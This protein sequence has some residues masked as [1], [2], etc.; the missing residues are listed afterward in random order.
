MAMDI[1]TMHIKG[2]FSGAVMALG[3]LA[4]SASL[5]FTDARTAPKWFTDGVMYQ[6]QPRAFTPEGTLKA[7]EGKLP[8]LKETGITIVYL[9][10]V[11]KMDGRMDR[12]F[13]SP[14]QVKSG[15]NIPK[16]QYCIADYFHVDEEYGTDDDLRA[17]CRRAHELGMRVVFDLVYFHCA[18]HARILEQIPDA[19]ARNPDGSAKRGP[20][21]FPKL[22]FKSKAVREYL[23]TNITYL[24]LEYGVDGFRCDVGPGI[25]LDFWIEAHDRMDALSS[26]NAILLC[27]GHVKNDQQRAFDADYGWFPHPGKDASA[28]RRAWTG[29]ERE[30]DRG[31]R[32]VNHYENHDI[33]TDVRPRREAAWGHDFVDQVLVWMFT[34]DGVPLLFNGNEIADDDPKHSMFGH[35]PI[36]W[37][38]LDGD[39]GKARRALVRRLAELR[40]AHPVFTALN[41]YEGLAWLDVTSPREVTAFVRRM[42]GGEMILVVQNWSAKEVE[43]TV[44][45]DTAEPDLPYFVVN[46]DPVDRSVK[47]NPSDNPLMSRRS[48]KTG[49]ATYRLGPHGFCIA[50]V[51]PGQ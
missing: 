23:L 2:I 6:I 22:N 50:V 11:F 47:G 3:A 10:P 13:W 29:R 49:P 38:L 27:E 8:Y 34:I 1:K 28:I 15:F 48:T 46:D 12:S 16:N 14:R 5:H 41:G 40:A 18:P 36:D 39:A 51:E 25:P 35:T 45:L 21:R 30:S 7:A 43:A 42:Q 24:M 4:A 19:A 17:F 26:G 33:A 20:W 37:S 9:L 31:A 32:F 44:K